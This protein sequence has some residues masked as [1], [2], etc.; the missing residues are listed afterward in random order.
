MWV[1]C[2]L[3]AE[4]G[5]QRVDDGEVEEPKRRLAGERKATLTQ[6]NGVYIAGTDPP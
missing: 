5:R 2:Q 4:I 3:G 1:F 6:N